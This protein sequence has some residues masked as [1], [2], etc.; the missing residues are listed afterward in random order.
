MGDEPEI[1]PADDLLHARWRLINIPRGPARNTSVEAL[2]SPEI[3]ELQDWISA[4]AFN[5]NLAKNEE[6][7][8]RH[9]FLVSFRLAILSD[10][11]KK[12]DVP[13]N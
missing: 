2:M 5:T 1:L 10:G 3:L 7:A 8:P 6:Q 4:C 9:F 12:S 11:G 13:T